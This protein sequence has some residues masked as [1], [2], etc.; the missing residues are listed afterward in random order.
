MKLFIFLVLLINIIDIILNTKS[1][2]NTRLAVAIGILLI[3]FT[4]ILDRLI[5]EGMFL[6]GITY[7]AISRN[8]AIGKGNFWELYYR[9]AWPFSEHPPLMF[10]LQALFFKVFGDHYLTEKLYSFAIW[11]VTLLLLRSIWNRSDNVSKHSYSLPL[12]LWC[13]I[14]TVTWSYTNNILDTTMAM[15]DLGAVFLLYKGVTST[16]NSKVLYLLGGGL[17]TFAAMFTKGP[18]GAFPLAV[19]GLYWLINNTSDFKKLGK[20]V[21]QTIMLITVV[22]GCYTLLYQFPESRANLER[23]LQEQL[24]A[25]LAGKREITGG[26]L[27]RFTLLYEL[28]MQML[29]PLVLTTV[30]IIVSKLLKLKSS[31]FAGNNKRALFFLLIGVAASAPIMLSV[32]QRSFYLIPSLPFYVLALTTLLYPYYYAITERLSVGNKGIK[33]FKISASVIAVGL[34]VYLGSKVGQVGRDHQLISNMKY[35]QQQFPKGQVFGICAEGD[36]DYEF[37]AYLQRYNRM[38]VDP[39]FYCADYVLIDKNVCNNEIIPIVSQLG[40]KQQ[41][42][43]LEQYVL[44]RRQLPLRFSFTL[45]NPVF[46]TRDK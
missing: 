28:V 6:D 13:I 44:Y 40:F 19:P 2:N 15:L 4:L 8:L 25:A 46:R 34:C 9:N 23:Y 10:G 29:P 26:G 32:K 14:P 39:V 7:A 11:L 30:L 38:E 33:Y 16:N 41:D 27:G 45:L 21:L 31:A 12:L 43:E 17:L 20:I 36:K 35:L 5:P 22:A 42:F 1:G 18:V 3:T 37:L 24:M